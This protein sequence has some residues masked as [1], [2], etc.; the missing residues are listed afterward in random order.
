[1][2]VATLEGLATVEVG[3]VV[4][5][6]GRVEERSWGLELPVTRLF[7]T[8][9]EIGQRRRETPAPVV[10]GEGGV[11]IP[12]PEIAAPGLEAFNTALFSAD[13]FESLEGMLVRVNDP[14]VVGPTSRY[15]EVVVLTDLGRSA[16][17]RTRRGGVRLLEHNVNPQRVVID[18]RLVADPAHLLVGDELAGPVDGVLHY[19]Y[20]S[21]KLLNTEPLPEVRRS[22][23]GRERTTLAADDSH[24][25]VATF[26]LEN[27]SAVSEEREFACL[28]SIVA[29]RL[30]APDIVA[31]QEVQDDT[32]PEDDGTVSSERTLELLVRAVEAAG[33]PR[34]EV[35]FIDP[36]D[37]GDGGQPGANIRTAF[38]FNPARVD[39][40]DRERCPGYPRTEID[41]RGVLTCSPGL[42][43]PDHP[44]FGVWEGDRSGSRKPLVGEFHFAGEPVFLI[45]LHLS[46]K[47]GDDPV[48]GRRQPRVE[49]SSRRRTEQAQVV[50]NFVE[51]IVRSNADARVVVLGDLNDFENTEPVKA[52]E[53]A[54]LEDLVTRLPL[55]I[56]YSF[57]YLG[58]SQVLDHI[59]V[60]EALAGDAEVEMVHVNAEFPAADRASDH[61]PVIA[62]FRL[63]P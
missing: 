7:A 54:G 15:G 27:L 56:R 44:A 10:I 43:D 46:S 22:G 36:A 34:Y 58:N 53:D 13:A 39:F 60:S 5:L 20:G 55:D 37:G 29:D 14:V 28:A 6:E 52:L 45:N 50:A 40:A 3:D 59:L 1:L 12:Q 8:S 57:V 32:G 35:R 61:D 51:E 19:T 4:R 16:M 18:D 41:E 38:L 17:Q 48:F 9:L 31:V 49:V 33:G 21:Y 30:G 63:A 25:T 26:N 47:G 24:L 42:V 2:F 23:L 11:T 62:R